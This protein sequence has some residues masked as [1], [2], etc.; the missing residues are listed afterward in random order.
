MTQAT[1]KS[2]VTSKIQ[3]QAAPARPAKRKRGSGKFLLLN[4]LLARCQ[5]VGNEETQAAQLG[6]PPW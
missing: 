2:Q 3:A 6:G 4:L 5:Q 1:S